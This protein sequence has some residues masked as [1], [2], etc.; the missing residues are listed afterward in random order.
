MKFWDLPSASLCA[1]RKVYTPYYHRHLFLLV[2]V[3][4]IQL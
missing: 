1:T 4:I 3:R 2:E